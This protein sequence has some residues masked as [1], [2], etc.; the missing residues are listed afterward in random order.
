MI[1]NIILKSV[2]LYQKTISLDQGIFNFF[3]QIRICRFYP[4]C[5]EYFY[6]S[7]KKYGAKTGVWRGIKRIAKCHP[8]HVGGVDM[9]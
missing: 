6:Q 7:V 2:K 1:K 3:I 4:T 8:W 9:P 5:S